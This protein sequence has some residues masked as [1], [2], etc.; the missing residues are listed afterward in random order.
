M[1]KNATLESIHKARAAHESQMQKIDALLN[2]EKVNNPTAV[3]KTECSFGKWLYA[4][5]SNL[6]R[7]LGA[8]FYSNIEIIHAKW[9]SEYSRLFNIFF[10]NQE[11]KGFFS[12]LLGNSKVD[13]MDIDKAELYYSELKSTTKELLKVL[14]ICERRVQ[15][16]NDSKFS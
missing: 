10:K 13:G 8:L 4:K 3:L 1:D 16:L 12:K 7:V 14:D 6:K 11:K 5:D 2:G 15:A 9:H